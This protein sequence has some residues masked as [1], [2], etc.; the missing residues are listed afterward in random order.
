ML[1]Q[2]LLLAQLQWLKK[3][4]CDLIGVLGLE[5]N[6]RFGVGH[7]IDQWMESSNS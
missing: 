4:F 3:V 7:A 2:D 6:S 5:D 1:L